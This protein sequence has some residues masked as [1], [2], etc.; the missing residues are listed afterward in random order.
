MEMMDLRDSKVQRAHPV[1][2]DPLATKGPLEPPGSLE[3]TEQMVL[4]GIQDQL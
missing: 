1:L 2:L 4:M 3:M